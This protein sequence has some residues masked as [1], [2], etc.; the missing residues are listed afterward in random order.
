MIQSKIDPEFIAIVLWLSALLVSNFSLTEC[1]FE[2]MVHFY[3]ADINH[4]PFKAGFV[5]RHTVT[6]TFVPIFVSFFRVIIFTYVVESSG[7]KRLLAMT[8]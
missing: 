8:V 6:C 5:L 2:S 3:L 4:L 7:Q 1:L